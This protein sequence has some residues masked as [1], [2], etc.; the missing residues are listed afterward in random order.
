M[1]KKLEKVTNFKIV[2]TC[3]SSIGNVITNIV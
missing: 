3:E 1:N 2:V